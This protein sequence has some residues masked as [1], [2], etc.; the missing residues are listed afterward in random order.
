MCT[1]HIHRPGKA[2]HP[3]F[4]VCI[5]NSLSCLGGVFDA[6]K[7]TLEVVPLS[8]LTP[9]KISYPYICIFVFLS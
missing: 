7:G 5:Q 1:Y 4:H 8:L 9:S 2:S 6:E 3:S